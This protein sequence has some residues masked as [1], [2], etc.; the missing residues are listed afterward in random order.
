MVLGVV[1]EFEFEF[2]TGELSLKAEVGL[3]C[4]GGS[5][6]LAA[7]AEA[8]V[9]A[10]AGRVALKDASFVVVVVVVGDASA[11]VLAALVRITRERCIVV[12][13]NNIIKYCGRE[14]RDQYRYQYTKPRFGKGTLDSERLPQ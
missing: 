5:L 10:D 4:L 11:M 3:S 12:S 2:E 8:V 9:V 1:V 6:L 7:T 13:N 14:V